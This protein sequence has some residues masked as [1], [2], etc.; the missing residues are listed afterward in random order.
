MLAENFTK[1]LQGSLFRNF[2]AEMINLPEGLEDLDMKW[3]VSKYDQDKIIK[4]H[5][6]NDNPI[7]QDCV[8]E[9]E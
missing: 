4:L 9:Y 3:E 1:L 8:A 5:H 7:P 6:V 2:L